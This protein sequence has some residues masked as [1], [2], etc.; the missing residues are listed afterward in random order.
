MTS[1][2]PAHRE[3]SRLYIG[4]MSGTSVD[5]VDGVLA[6]LG[7]GQPPQVLAS[8]SLP[9]PTDLRQELLALNLSGEDELARGA[10]AA[11]ALARL[12]AQAVS[13]LLRE[14]GVA[15]R[16]V[17]AIGAHGQTVRHRPDSGY[18][19]QLNAP[20]LLAELSG[21]DV[22]ADFRS[23][24]VAAGGQG[25]PLV[26]PF[27]AAIFGAPEGRAVLNLGGIANVTL[28][29]PGKSPRGFD[30]GPANVFLDGWCQRHLGAP[31]DADGRWA[32][33]GQVLAPLLELLIASEPWF[34][35]P[36]PKSTG[37]DL[38]NMQWLDSRLAEFDGPRPAPQDVQATLQRLTA[39]TVA[40][41]IDAAAAGTREVFVCGGGARNPGLM[42]ELAYCLQRPVRATDALGV[43]A[44]QVEAL[45]FAWLAQAF[46][47]RRP[48]GL[49][50]V[51]GAR[52]P[53]IL[54]ALYPA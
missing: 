44:Q 7:D 35:L 11:N 48:A 19:V 17:A 18:T 20:A 23:R 27:H 53:R 47:A 34:A 36:P 54:G 40:N 25:A 46:V 1:P 41:A 50:D 15:A 42:R 3:D 10:L 38:F 51:T 13:D 6:R 45:A 39:R 43:P 2:Q 30:T 29:E 9:M 28:L 8:A 21:I 16:D 31:Y 49:P 52:G 5:G 24:D 22:V 26:P 14:A 37:R 32:A 4:L 33:S 12:Y